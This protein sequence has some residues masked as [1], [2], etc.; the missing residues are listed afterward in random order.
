MWKLHSVNLVATLL[1]FKW[2]FCQYRSFL[3]WLLSSFD[4]TQ[5]EIHCD[6]MVTVSDL[7]VNSCGLTMEPLLRSYIFLFSPCE[8]LIILFVSQLVRTVSFY[9]PNI[10]KVYHT[11]NTKTICYFHVSV[12][13]LYMKMQGRTGKYKQFVSHFIPIPHY[14]LWL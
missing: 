6:R 4:S 14:M 1:L 2:W 7:L 11:Y 5:Y 3:F 13:A 8:A 12:V 9:N 10:Q